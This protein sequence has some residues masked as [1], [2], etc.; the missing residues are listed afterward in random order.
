MS[1]E[2]S[3]LEPETKLPD[4]KFKTPVDCPIEYLALDYD[5][6]RFEI[7]L[8]HK[9]DSEI[10]AI[11]RLCSISDIKEL[12]DS[13][14]ING[15]LPIE[16]MI[17]YKTSSQVKYTVLEGNRRLAAIKILRDNNIAKEM[18]IS[19][20]KL[21]PKK[22]Q[23]TNKIKVFRV[24]DPL[25][26]R[27]FIGFK[28]INGPQR[29]DSYAKAKFATK[30]YKDFR[31]ENK[32]IE[33]VAKQ[34]GDNNDTIRSYVSSILVLEQA[35]NNNIYNIKDKTS[36]GKFA[37]SHL[38]TALDRLEYRNFLGLKQGWNT[39]PIENP[40]PKKYLEKLR[41]VLVY[42]YG[43]KKDDKEALVKSQ[44]PDLKNL[45]II[46]SNEVALDKIRNGMN[47]E[48]AYLNTLDSG[49]AL[50]KILVD[51]NI[52][53][54]RGIDILSKLKAEAF[55]PSLQKLSNEIIA[56]VEILNG[57]I[58]SRISGKK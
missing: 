39:E 38:Y 45:G 54:R 5:N 32:T 14:S 42:I 24:K 20:P 50:K 25:E 10:E 11:R 58:N 23:T 17:I 21:D 3:K 41:E 1:K 4:L 9:R 51:A 47:I 6:P 18:G 37:F 33:D 52:T 19:V 43:S 27:A 46:L 16:P 49:D 28:H 2:K 40:I 22:L 57:F 26:A 13:I 31:K 29:W 36:R 35:E 7:D 15:Y 44:N 30:W 56:Q 34:L 55:S 8:D 53:L 12:I 48:D